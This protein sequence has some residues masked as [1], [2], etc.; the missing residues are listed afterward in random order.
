MKDD[1]AGIFLT[2]FRNGQLPGPL[3]EL[4]PRIDSALKTR[5]RSL[6]FSA[7]VWRA[8][9]ENCMRGQPPEK[10]TEAQRA[11]L[12]NLLARMGTATNQWRRDIFDK[13]LDPYLARGRR[14]LHYRFEMT[15]ARPANPTWLSLARDTAMERWGSGYG[16]TP[17]V[18]ALEGY[19]DRHPYGDQLQLSL[20]IPAGQGLTRLSADGETQLKGKAAVGVYDVLR[21]PGGQTAMKIKIAAAADPTRVQIEA[22]L[23]SHAELT[24]ADLI[25]LAD[26]QEEAR[27]DGLVK[28]MLKRESGRGRWAGFTNPLF[29][30]AVLRVP[31]QEPK[32][33]SETGKA[34]PP[35]PGP[36]PVDTGLLK[37]LWLADFWLF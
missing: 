36:S 14:P 18:E 25:V 3:D 31:E 11:L 12:R 17:E 7:L 16:K 35:T 4:A 33:Q 5:Q 22:V 30:P 27:L 1:P 24:Y 8:V 28:D 10:R 26:R 2:Q 19:L 37:R 29:L 20:D 32:T 6:S 23:P 15:K 9:A 34:V 21:T 13:K